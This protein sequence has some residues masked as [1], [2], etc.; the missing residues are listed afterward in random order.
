MN[1]LSC[2]INFE[3]KVERVKFILALYYTDKLEV[4]DIRAIDITILKV[5]YIY[6]KMI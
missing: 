3:E 6:F 4:S 2:N 5:F 1:V